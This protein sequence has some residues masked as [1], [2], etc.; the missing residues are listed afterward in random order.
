VGSNTDV[1]GFLE[2]LR[3]LLEPGHDY[4]FASVLG[5]GGAAA[6]ASYALRAAGF[7]VISYGRTRAK[8]QAFRDSLGLDPDP[9]FALEICDL[10]GAGVVAGAPDPNRLDLLVNATPLGMRGFAPLEIDLDG[11]SRD[12]IVYDLVYTPV[13]TDLLRAAR[14]RGMPTI[15]GLAML[16]GQAALAFELFFEA[17]A[18]RE[19]D[20]ELLDLLAQ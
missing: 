7:L 10:V 5:T 20:A 15:D 17:P 8:A 11:W 2:P 6:A 14:V 12:V 9:D 4:L 13:E 16:V 18:P 1:E 3:P 19:H